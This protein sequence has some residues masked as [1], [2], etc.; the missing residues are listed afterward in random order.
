MRVQ[1][2][3]CQSI[4]N[5]AR[6]VPVGSRAR[7][8]RCGATFVVTA[9]VPAQAVQPPAKQAQA[10]ATAPAAA[11]DAI[12][13]AE[14]IEDEP[15]AAA[16]LD[17]DE[18][19]RVADH[20][21]RKRGLSV[22]LWICVA[23]ILF[24]LLFGGAATLYYVVSK[25]RVALALAGGTAITGWEPDPVLVGFLDDELKLTPLENLHIHISKKAPIRSHVEN[26]GRVWSI[27]QL[28]SGLDGEGTNLNV[29]ILDKPAAL[30]GNPFM[31]QAFLHNFLPKASNPQSGT[32]NGM[33]FTRVRTELEFHKGFAYFG[34]VDNHV[35]VLSSYETEKN[36]PRLKLAESAVLTL[37]KD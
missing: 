28:G 9:E 1:C 25:G 36:L 5:S 21:E 7:C 20:A 29:E 26:W 15:V 17:D 4:L 31:L 33:A 27:T 24:A 13:V 37:R 32:I 6:P 34:V 23:S 8:P 3:A 18:A 2:T 19:I 10:Q 22:G 16:E 14:M 12:P 35:I 11:P 30:E